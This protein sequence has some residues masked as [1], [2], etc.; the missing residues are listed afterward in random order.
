MVPKKELARRSKKGRRRAAKASKAHAAAA[1]VEIYQELMIEHR[2]VIK[3]LQMMNRYCA[4][5]AQKL[6]DFQCLTGEAHGRDA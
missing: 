4:F 6:V 2:M 5:L 1:L 3:Q